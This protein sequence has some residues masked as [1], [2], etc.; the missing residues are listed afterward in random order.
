MK[1]YNLFNLYFFIGLLL[2][3]VLGIGISMHGSYTCPVKNISG[4]HCVSCGMTRDFVQFIQFNF[5]SPI[6]PNSWR[7][8]TWVMTQIILRGIGILLLRNKVTNQNYLFVDLII[9]IGILIWAVYP[10]WWCSE[11]LLN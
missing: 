3:A 10:L 5:D 9:T 4:F 11:N 6:N 7:L 1:T 2:V 8:F